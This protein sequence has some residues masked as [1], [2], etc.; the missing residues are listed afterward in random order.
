MIFGRDRYLCVPDFA[1]LVRTRET[2]DFGRFWP[3]LAHFGSFGG[4]NVA[5]R[6]SWD[7]VYPLSTPQAHWGHQKAI[8]H[9]QGPYFFDFGCP[10]G[11]GAPL[12]G[13]VG[14]KLH[15]SPADP[16]FLARWLRSMSLSPW[17][18]ENGSAGLLWS[19]YAHKKP[20]GAARAP[21]GA[22]IEGIRPLR[23]RNCFLVSPMCSGCA[24]WVYQVPGASGRNTNT[25]K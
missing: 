21:W 9:T 5:P 13:F 15:K 24:E 14:I 4:L 1:F 16:F 25:P 11:L 8:S 12:G 6:C 19:F 23:M 20:Q 22:K 10:R 3:V 2:K 7:L 18:K 17:A